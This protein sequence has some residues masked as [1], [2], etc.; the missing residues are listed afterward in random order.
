MIS[1]DR[2]FKVLLSPRS[3]EKSS[4]FI[5]KTNTMIFKVLRNA[6]KIE[7]K[8]AIEKIFKM[9]VKSVNTLVIK[10]KKK[11]KGN[12]ITCHKN[13]KKAYITIKKGQNIDQISNI[14]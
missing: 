3:S 9:E 12:K 10:G 6:R 11:K 2:L 5:K 7:I 14:D 1:D 8:L 4:I 13:W